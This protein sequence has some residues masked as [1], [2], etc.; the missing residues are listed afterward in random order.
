MAP[1]EVEVHTAVGD[2]F[3]DAWDPTISL[4]EWRVRLLESGWAVPSWSSDWFGRGLPAW[5]DRVAHAAIRRA[6]GVT[7][8]LGAGASLAAPTIHEH[9]SDDL[10]RRVLG[11]AVRAVPQRLLLLRRAPRCGRGAARVL[12]QI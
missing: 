11:A 10:R 9:G 12:V 1:T 5:A 7:L 2:W 6:G 4:L 3:A 8:P